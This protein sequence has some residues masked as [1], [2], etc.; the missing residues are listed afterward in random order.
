M[1][2]PC[3]LPAAPSAAR[4][5][6]RCSRG[7]VGAADRARSRVSAPTGRPSRC[8][9]CSRRRWRGGWRCR[10]TRSPRTSTGSARSSTSAARGGREAAATNYELLYPLLDMATAL[11][12]YFNIAYR[13]GAIF[14]SEPKPGGPGR[15]DLAIALLQKGMKA[16]PEQ[17]GVHAGHRASSTTGRCKDYKRAAEWF[18]RGQPRSR[19]RRG[20]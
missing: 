11:D 3:R 19:A 4:P 20:S 1:I 5:S 10:T 12:P 7:G 2:A 8:S 16:M 13:F 14:L 15:P 17:V 9:T 6:R 18:E